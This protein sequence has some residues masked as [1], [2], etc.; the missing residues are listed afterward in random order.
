MRTLLNL[1]VVSDVC[2]PALGAGGGAARFTIPAVPL[3]FVHSRQRHPKLG[4]PT[5][6]KWQQTTAAKTTNLGSVFPDVQF[7]PGKGLTGV[8]AQTYPTGLS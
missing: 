8:V 4:A 5:R 6:T 1:I 3:S 7:L 2:K